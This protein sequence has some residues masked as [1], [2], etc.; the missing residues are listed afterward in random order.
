MR[1]NVCTHNDKMDTMMDTSAFRAVNLMH[2]IEKTH[3]GRHLPTTDPNVQPTTEPT[4]EPDIDSS[5]QPT[6]EPS[7]EPDTDPSAQ[8]STEPSTNPGAV[9][10]PIQVPIQA[11]SQVHSQPVQVLNQP[12]GCHHLF[13]MQGSTS[14]VREVECPN[15]VTF[16][17]LLARLC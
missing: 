17:C 2:C 1:V 8:P 14:P 7:A 6:T 16:H 9:Q 11:P 5:A 10:P 3:V 15:E 13:N 4:T 12:P